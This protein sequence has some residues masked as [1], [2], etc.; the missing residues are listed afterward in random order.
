[1]EQAGSYAE[2]IALQPDGKILLGGRDD[3]IGAG[4]QRTPLA[5]LV[6][7]GP[8][9]A[10]DSS[11]GSGGHVED[12]PFRIAHVYV[13]TDHELLVLGEDEN[14]RVGAERYTAG[15]GPDSSFGPRG[16]R[17]FSVPRW[18]VE[19]MDVAGRIVVLGRVPENEIEA[20]RF[21]PS[22]APDTRFGS[23]GVARVPVPQVTQDEEMA[24]ATQRDGSIIVAGVT[25]SHYRLRQAKLPQLFLAR[26]TS[27]G[28]LDPSFGK[29][30]ISHVPITVSESFGHPLVASLVLA[31]APDRHILLA[32]DQA[33]KLVLASY[34]GAGMLDHSFGKNGIALSALPINGSTLAISPNAITFDAVGDALVA[35]EHAFHTVDVP[36]GVWTLARYTTHGRDCSF[37]TN[38]TVVGEAPS[39]ANA[40]AVQPNGRIVIAGWSKKSFLAARYMGGGTPRTCPGEPSGPKPLRHRRHGPKAGG[41]TAFGG[42]PGG[43]WGVGAALVFAA[44][45]LPI[46]ALGRRRRTLAA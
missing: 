31:V 38:G 6:R 5:A 21:L 26:L 17:W 20:Y 42:T 19:G 39:G 37:G 8:N 14:G 33:R 44:L 11:F 41:A 22:G 34:T 13:T 28:K 40:V 15:G 1:V 45:V 10:L 12:T 30:G 9:G 18:S 25:R 7:F 36:A 29:G 35:G 43:G 16:V 32:T 24:L 46:R 27:A 23:Q 2:G 3:Y 4:G